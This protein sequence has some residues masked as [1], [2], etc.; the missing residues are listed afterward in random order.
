MVA[1]N[2]L[3]PSLQLILDP[4]IESGGEITT[5]VVLYVVN[6][7]RLKDVK[8]VDLRLDRTLQDLVHSLLLPR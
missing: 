8:D 3:P 7:M 1:L 4:I 2:A 5:H 6:Q